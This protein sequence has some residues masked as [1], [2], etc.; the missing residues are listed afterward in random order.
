MLFL[1]PLTVC[2]VF[3]YF[4]AFHNLLLN[5][6]IKC[7]KC[8]HVSKTEGNNERH[9]SVPI[10]VPGVGP[11]LQL[12]IK[13]YMDEVVQGYRCGNEKCKDTSDKHRIQK[14]AYAPDVL[15]VQLK[16]FD[17]RGRKDSSRLHYGL[18]LDL[19][20]HAANNNLGPLTYDLTA[21]ISHA[22]SASFGHYICLA[23]SPDGS[24]TEFDDIDVWN[25]NV[26]EAINPGVISR[27]WTPY[28]LFYQRSKTSA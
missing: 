19:S 10:K 9:L 7:N 26:K 1:D 28:L 14:I 27:D 16:R 5:S 2:S 3:G 8:G 15:L 17:H 23:K 21:V 13:D 18:R 4:E 22:G 12:Y 20:P 24:W 11:H 25:S 6:E